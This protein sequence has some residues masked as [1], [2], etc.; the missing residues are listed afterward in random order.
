MRDGARAE[1]PGGLDVVGLL[2]LDDRRPHDPGELVQPRIARTS[3]DLADRH[4]STGCR[5]VRERRQEQ[6]AAEQQRDAEEDVGEPGQDRVD[7]AA[8]VAG[9]HADDQPDDAR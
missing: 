1:G 3:D 2:D 4:D 8:V 5:V 7:D 9:E 6:D